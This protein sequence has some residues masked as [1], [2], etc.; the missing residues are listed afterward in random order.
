MVCSWLRRPF[1]SILGLVVA[2]SMSV[3][4]IQV[5]EISAWVTITSATTPTYNDSKCPD[6][7]QSGRD[8]NATDCLLAICGGPGLAT[9]V[10][11][12]AV[13]IQTD[14]LDQPVWVQPLLVGWAHP[15]DPYPPRPRTLD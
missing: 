11:T 4:V 15:P 7:D 9:L 5:T 8:M 13:V 3:S 1:A 10:S 2:A 6:C 14:G 12:L